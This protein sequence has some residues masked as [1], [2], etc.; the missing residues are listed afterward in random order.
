MKMFLG[1]FVLTS[2]TGIVALSFVGLGP[3]PVPS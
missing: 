2:I 1:A 3:K